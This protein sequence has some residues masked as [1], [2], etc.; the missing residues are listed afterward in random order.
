MEV[1]YGYVKARTSSSRDGATP[2]NHRL[3]ARP[4]A[5]SVRKPYITA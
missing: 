1:D 3:D 5:I 4:V 2:P